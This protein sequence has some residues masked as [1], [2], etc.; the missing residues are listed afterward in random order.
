MNAWRNLFYDLMGRRFQELQQGDP[1]FSMRKYAKVA[2]VSPAAMLQI[3]R[4]NVIWNLAPEKAIE[5]VRSAGLK[6]EEINYFLTTVGKVPELRRQ[7]IKEGDYDILT[8]WCYLPILHSF[9]LSE[10]PTPEQL[11]AKLGLS[12]EKVLQVIQDLSA[13]GY[14]RAD[15]TGRL[16]RERI[17]W[18][19]S[20][21][22][23]V[24]AIRAHHDLSLNLS[25][26]ALDVLPSEQRNFQSLTFVGN[27]EQISEI[28]EEM[29]KFIKRVTAIAEGASQK[30]ELYKLS[31]QFFPIQDFGGQP[32]QKTI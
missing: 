9:D 21:G 15:E 32:P 31:L 2:C 22:P 16:Y 30:D 3:L 23:P 26:K 18:H 17:H 29:Q 4:R 28:R 1:G 5:I 20:D 8:D 27:R 7:E 11:A 12:A 13:R 10:R 19:T 14:L 24:K 25:Q 6:E